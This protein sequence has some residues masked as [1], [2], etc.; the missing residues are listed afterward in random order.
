MSIWW[1][2]L[3]WYL[4]GVAIG[5]ASP[6][7]QLIESLSI[8]GPITLTALF[9]SLLVPFAGLSANEK[10]QKF[11]LQFAIVPLFGLYTVL[12]WHTAAI[13]GI[14]LFVMAA[15]VHVSYWTT[16]FHSRQYRLEQCRLAFG[17]MRGLAQLVARLNGLGQ[18]HVADEDIIV[19]LLHG[20]AISLERSKKLLPNAQWLLKEATD[21]IE[22]LTALTCQ[23]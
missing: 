5:V 15:G 1:K 23:R 12:L 18:C 17:H 4:A 19:P 8:L 7:P 14:A 3:A 21:E 16:S 20:K 2:Y 10:V 11:A 6:K 9:A 22:R 13:G